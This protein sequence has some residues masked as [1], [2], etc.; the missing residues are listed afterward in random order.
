[1]DA[2][3]FILVVAFSA[4]VAIVIFGAYERTVTRVIGVI[5]TNTAAMG[6]LA[7]GQ[8]AAAKTATGLEVRLVDTVAAIRELSERVTQLTKG[9]GILTDRQDTQSARQ[10]G[11][12]EREAAR[13][14]VTK[15]T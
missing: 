13:D 1:M 3:L 10:T 2:I 7:D 5:E 4:S 9:Q 12:E 14:A 11:M 6:G 15:V 8:R